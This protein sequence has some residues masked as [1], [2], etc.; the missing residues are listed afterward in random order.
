MV[1]CFDPSA[2]VSV[3]IFQPRLRR[4]VLTLQMCGLNAKGTESERTAAELK[5]LLLPQT[6]EIIHMELVGHEQ[7]LSPPTRTRNGLHRKLPVSAQ[8]A[9]QTLTHTELTLFRER[10]TQCFLGFERSI[11]S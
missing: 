10:E 4:G 11:Y 9:R 1:H 6:I 7:R 5:P 2:L 8:A 3:V